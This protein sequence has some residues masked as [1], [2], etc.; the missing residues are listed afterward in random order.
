[1]ITRSETQI[2]DQNSVG[3]YILCIYEA[4]KK[5]NKNKNISLSTLKN[6]NNNPRL[7]Y[8]FFFIMKVPQFPGPVWSV[9]FKSGY[10]QS[11]TQDQFD[12]FFSKVG[13]T[14]PTPRTSLV[15]CFQKWVPVQHPGLVWS[16]VFK[17]GYQSNTDYDDI[18]SLFVWKYVCTLLFLLAWENCLSALTKQKRLAERQ[19]LFCSVVLQR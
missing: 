6:P 16:V 13:T 7:V 3:L 1:L 9:V 15:C 4:P 10:H 5:K 2:T 17:S 12:L 18:V 19:S 14:S 11:N 8:N